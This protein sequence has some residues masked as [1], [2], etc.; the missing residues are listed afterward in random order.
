MDSD[1]RVDIKHISTL[2]EFDAR[3]ADWLRLAAASRS[4]GLFNGWHW[5]RLWWQ[6]YGNLGDLFILVVRVDGI[7]QGIAPLYQMQSRALRLLSVRT[8]RFI[9]TGG[10]T[11]P[12]DLD[13]LYHP[14]HEALVAWHLSEH[15]LQLASIERMQLVDMP[16]DSAFHQ[17]LIAGAVARGW[18][19]PLLSHQQRRIGSLPDSIESYEKSMSSNARKHRKRR[20]KQIETAGRINGRYCQTPEQ[21][22]EAFQCLVNLHL[23]RRASKGTRSDSFT[24]SEYRN[25]HL[26]LMQHTL[27]RDELRLHVLSIDDHIV[28]V[29]YGFLVNG[30]LSLFQTG[31]DPRY[32]HLSPGHLLMM[33]LIDDAI[34]DGAHTVDLL[35]G[36]YDYKASYARHWKKTVSVDL[37]RRGFSSLAYRMRHATSGRR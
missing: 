26:S 15:L 1:S 21:V 28:G 6:H 16:E 4:A 23:T 3:E 19:E 31:F 35:K 36:D 25:F 5:N 24:S 8:V 11:S 2:R 12:D 14:D 17:A 32:E 10:D 20:R 37:W 7:I 34:L 27:A 13:V 29:E 22:Q 9:G 33:R 30:V 18:S